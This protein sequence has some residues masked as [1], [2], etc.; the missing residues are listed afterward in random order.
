MTRKHTK[1]VV[2]AVDPMA[3]YRVQGRVTTFSKSEQAILNLPV[4][5]ALQALIDRTANEHDFHTLAAATNIATVCAE[6]IDPEVERV[7]TLGMDALMRVLDRHKKTEQWGMDGPARI[8]LDGV[9]DVYEQLTSLL[10]GGQIK[11]AMTEVI[12][13]MNS[14]HVL[15][16]A[17]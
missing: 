17:A 1:R 3:L 7:C 6:K 12:R 8:E 2:R 9:V 4:R 16:A 13:R 11:D 14:G 5:L 15:K 10:T